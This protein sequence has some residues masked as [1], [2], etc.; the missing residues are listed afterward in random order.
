MSNSAPPQG[1]P[2]ISRPVE[3][4]TRIQRPMNCKVLLLNGEEY[5]VAIDKRS[6]GQLLYERVCDYLDLLERDY[7]GLQYK[8][9]YDPE[10]VKFWLDLSKKVTKQKKRGKMEFEFA[11][12][13]YP[14]DP[15]QLTESLTRYLVC[16][17]IRR[18]IISGKLPCSQATHAM[19]GSY[20]VQ[21]D[22]G[23]YDPIDHG[24]GIDYI[25]DMPFAPD[26]TEDLLYKIAALH[27]QHK[28]QTP[29][30]AEMHYLEYSKKIALY[31]VDLHKAK[32]SD[33]VDILLGVGSTG[34]SVYRDNL[35]INR[36][37]W[38]KILKISYRRNKFL[39]RIR[40]AEFE[41]YESWVAFRLPNNKMAKRI[42]K[43]SVEHHAFLRLRSADDAKKRT[44]FPRFGSKYRYSGRTLYQTRLNASM[45][46]RPSKQFERTHSRQSLNSVLNNNRS[47]SLDNL[48]HRR[49]P[50]LEQRT[51]EIQNL[52]FD[53]LR[54]ERM[55]IRNRTVLSRVNEDSFHEDSRNAS[56]IEEDR[57]PFQSPLPR[58]ESP[59]LI[60]RQVIR[61]PVPEEDSDLDDRLPAPPKESPEE[62][63]R[64]L[65]KKNVSNNAHLGGVPTPIALA[66]QTK[67]QKSESES[68][69]SSRDSRRSSRD[70][71]SSQGSFDARRAVQEVIPPPK[72][73]PEVAAKPGKEKP[74]V[75]KKPEK[76]PVAPK[77]GKKEKD[78]DSGKENDSKKAL[79]KE[80]KKDK[81]EKVTRKDSK[82]EKEKKEDKKDSK[83]DSK[84]EKDAKK[85][86]EST[87]S[88]KGKEEVRE[89]FM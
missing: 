65:P 21:A 57:T 22:I 59:K 76:P 71:A 28:G 87:A 58:E 33:Y 27:K 3:N 32:D 79:D 63:R 23:D 42:W 7:F 34:I 30:Q 18:D 17:Q 20:A 37:V 74:P 73:K 51:M 69:R 19:L 9:D 75:A 88:K 60:T 35:R 29:E 40:P 55:E 11:L 85:G 83:K 24:T 56:F 39:L 77:P 43:I 6:S 89:V 25:R 2:Q 54:E 64:I 62:V 1:P 70:S 52:S 26:Q 38:P 67:R 10:N 53:T 15:T 14:P 78:D 50:F 48:N 61:Q 81:K 49:E 41:T 16:L 80:S 8:E 68:D 13:F 82:K 46:D 45:A 47:R 31:G 66:V 72:L 12:K 84:K 44:G 36:F 86:K 5:E 4:K